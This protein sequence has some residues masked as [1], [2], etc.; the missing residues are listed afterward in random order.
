MIRRNCFLVAI[1]VS[2]SWARASGQVRPSRETFA[3]FAISVLPIHSVPAGAPPIVDSLWRQA[4]SAS[5]EFVRAFVPKRVRL[6]IG[7]EVQSLDAT[8]STVRRAATWEQVSER[9]SVVL[10]AGNGLVWWRVTLR[11]ASRAFSGTATVSTDEPGPTRAAV[12]AS[13]ISCP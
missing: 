13:R 7:G 3:C 12:A 9:D 4:D 11:G 10:R 1:L 5:T 6:L 8:P 2:L